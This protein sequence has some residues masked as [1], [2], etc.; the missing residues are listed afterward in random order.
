MTNLSIRK[1]T[2]NDEANFRAGLDAFAKT[3]PDFS[4]GFTLWNRTAPFQSYL[5]KLDAQ[6]A[7][8]NLK[9]GFVPNTVRFAFI[10]TEQGD[11]LAGRISFRHFL[12]ESLVKVGGHIG[13]AT[14][15]DFRGQGV[16]HQMLIQSLKWAREK[17]LDRVLLT[18]DDDNAASIRTIEKA[19]GV[20]ENTI[21]TRP[22]KPMKRRYWITIKY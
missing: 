8:I 17:K 1:L 2:L 19:G 13:Y 7:G 9:E 12:N 16:A 3:D 5:D 20:L 11:Q 4:F 21:K 14:I 10:K 15:P 6:E 18:C 22:G